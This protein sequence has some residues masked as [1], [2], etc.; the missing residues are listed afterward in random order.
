MAPP[1]LGHHRLE[2]LAAHPVVQQ[3]LAVLGQAGVVQGLILHVE[4][5]EPLQRTGVAT[6]P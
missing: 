6:I 5:Q 1:R 2:E 3:P 4:I